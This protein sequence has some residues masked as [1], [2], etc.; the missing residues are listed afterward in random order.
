MRGVLIRAAGTGGWGGGLRFPC[1][2]TTG[3]TITG[4][5]TTVPVPA[6]S[7]TGWTWNVGS[8]LVKIQTDNAVVSGL[9]VAGGLL[10][11]AN[12][13]T[14]SNCTFTGNC[15]VGGTSAGTTLS[16][17]R[18][19]NSGSSA[20]CITIAS[21]TSGTKVSRCTLS[22]VDP[23]IGRVAY[24]VQDSSN[25]P[26]TLVEYC[27]ICWWRV[28]GQAIAGTWRYNYIHD[29]GFLT[30]D[31]TDGIDVE[32]TAGHPLLI[33]GQHDPRPARPDRP[34]CTRTPR[35]S[36]ITDMTASGNLFA[37]GGYAVYG[38]NSGS[39]AGTSQ[40]IQFTGNWFSTM[41]YASGG[42]F[43]AGT[44]WNNTATGNA[45]SGNKWLDGASAGQTI[46]HP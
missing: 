21:G 34:P 7:G 8:S 13:V 23:G 6:T 36:A 1:A 26:D 12:G 24:G 20:A 41:Y 37:G 46:P 16:N 30:T 4:T 25:D 22:G 44:A 17:L 5:R 35:R 14:V 15:T 18:V 43:G 28:G 9:D 27:D 39:F 2:E 10:V 33:A 38:G 42:V 31:H 32:G 11:Q 19:T 29:A 40:G 3:A 45:W